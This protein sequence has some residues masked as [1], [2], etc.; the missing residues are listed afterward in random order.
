MAGVCVGTIIGLTESRV[1]DAVVTAS[2]NP[3]DSTISEKSSKHSPIDKS[4]SV[5]TRKRNSILQ[6]SNVND[7]LKRKAALVRDKFFF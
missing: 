1:N 7:E 5:A 4:E 2:T 6:H 3:P